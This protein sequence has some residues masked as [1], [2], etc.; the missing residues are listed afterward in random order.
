MK[1]YLSLDLLRG[2]SIFGM[3]YSALVP[4]G[5]LPV[6][7]YHIQN[8]PPTHNLDTTISG[9]SWVDLVFPIFIFCMGVAIPLSGRRKIELAKSKSI[10]MAYFSE[11][12]ERFFMLWL[13][14]YLYLFLNFSSVEGLWAQ[15]FTILGFISLFIFY[16]RYGKQFS[17]EKKLLIRGAG[18][19]SIIV[20]IVLGYSLFDQVISIYRSGII[21]FLLAFL[22]LF[23]SLIW[24]FTRDNL[25]NR[26]FVFS[27]ILLFMTL[28][29][30]FE[31]QGKLYSI[32]EIRW[33]F[34]M[35]YIYFLLILLPATYVGDLLHKQLSLSIEISSNSFKKV[36]KK[37]VVLALLLFIGGTIAYFIE[38]SI[39]KIP[40]TVS[41]CLITPAIAI[42]LLIISDLVV[43]LFRSSYFVRIFAGA[44]SNP[45]LSYVIFGNFIMSF[46]KLTG[47]IY[48]YQAA[49]PAGYPWI[50]VARAFCIVLFTMAIVAK[51]SEKK[52]YWR[53]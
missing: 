19:V 16:Y 38:G 29:V 23:G 22:Y 9:I 10:T 49:Y 26:L 44:G 12:L 46:F 4:A 47:I 31:I 45:L 35:E 27:V 28:T 53:A 34:N 1:R 33:F 20:L 3:V 43:D 11:T 30:P 41:Y 36:I 13:F 52:I 48:I 21:I 15:F 6:W 51:L 40:C 25:K 39:K 50:G 2:L 5:V 8:P 7:M 42:S 17:R 18:L 37:E 24:Y 32:K 14:S